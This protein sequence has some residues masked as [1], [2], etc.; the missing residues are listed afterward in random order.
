MGEAGA[1]QF[2]FVE[3]TRDGLLRHQWFI[4][5]R[6]DKVAADSVASER[7]SAGTGTIRR[8][9]QFGIV[10]ALRTPRELPLVS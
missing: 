3:W 8:L 7:G 2:C 10:R 6:T 5:A 1:V 9:I 4:G